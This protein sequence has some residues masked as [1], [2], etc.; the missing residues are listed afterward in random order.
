MKASSIV[1]FLTNHLQLPGADIGWT[2]GW[3][4][5]KVGFYQVCMMYNGGESMGQGLELWEWTLCQL[6][7][8]VRIWG[9]DQ[10]PQKMK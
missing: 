5:T 6:W 7:R 9:K 4:F 8:P 10:E 3:V 1:A 2:E